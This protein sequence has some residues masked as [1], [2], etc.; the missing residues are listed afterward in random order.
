MRVLLVDDCD[1]SLELLS[2][3]LE[4]FDVDNVVLAHDG[5]DALEQFGQQEFDLVVADW[6]M[7]NLNGLALLKEIRRQDQCIP[8]IMVTAHANNENFLAAWSS[9]GTGFLSKPFDP[10]EFRETVIRC[11][12]VI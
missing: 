1:I 6:E 3:C 12:S 5:E 4:S 2:N 7:P 8:V 11:V 9:G 10:K